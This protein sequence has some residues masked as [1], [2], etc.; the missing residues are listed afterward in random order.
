MTTIT[1]AAVKALRDETNVGMMECKKALIESGGDREKAILLLRERG[2]AIAGKR[3]GRA[4]RSGLIAARTAPDGAIG[5]MIEVNC[6]T[7]FVARNERFQ[8]FV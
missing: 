8:Q 2:V 5:A 1:A 7:D 3:A 6:E 4:A